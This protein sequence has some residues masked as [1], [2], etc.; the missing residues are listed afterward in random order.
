MYGVVRLTM[1]TEVVTVFVREQDTLSGQLV[2]AMCLDNGL[3]T[4][5]VVCVQSSA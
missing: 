3:T 5:N 1:R 4:T 2:Q